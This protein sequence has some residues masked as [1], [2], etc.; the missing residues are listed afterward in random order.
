MRSRWSGLLLILI[1]SVLPLSGQSAPSFAIA[2]A[3]TKP[4]LVTITHL[5]ALPQESV[6]LSEEG[7]AVEYR[8]ALL[9]AILA[10]AGA[11]AGSAMRGKALTN[12]VL[13]EAKDGYRVV[14]SLGEV[15]PEFGNARIIV[16]TARNGKPL[17]DYQGPFRLIVAGDKRGARGVRMLTKLTIVQPPD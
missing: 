6:S 4:G 9:S 16:A 11:P 15:D 1:T 5:A 2:G 7:E 13:A 8:G 14:F 10:R 12:Y 17:F 3:V